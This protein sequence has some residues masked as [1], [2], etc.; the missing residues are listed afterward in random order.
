M[1]ESGCM[2]EQWQIWIVFFSRNPLKVR[3]TYVESFVQRLSGYLIRFLHYWVFVL[4]VPLAVGLAIFQR[5]KRN[6]VLEVCV[7]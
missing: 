7:S 5:L 3:V 1:L 4:G 6:D 2:H